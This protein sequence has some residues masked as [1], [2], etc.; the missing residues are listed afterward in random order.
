MT[1]RKLPKDRWIVGNEE[2]GVNLWP[3]GLWTP[4]FLFDF[5]RISKVGPWYHIFEFNRGHMKWFVLERYSLKV[6]NQLLR[7]LLKRPAYFSWTRT[8]VV[9][10]SNALYRFG[11]E[12]LATD[13]HSL[14]NAVLL[15]IFSE[16]KKLV[17]ETIGYGMISTLTEIPHGQFVKY[18]AR[19]VPRRKGRRP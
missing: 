18:A 2:D 11:K 15:K 16:H 10:A 9:R 14:S 7:K 4:A 5:A 13:L 3:L 19:I 6:A 12:L 8:H 1:L 17:L